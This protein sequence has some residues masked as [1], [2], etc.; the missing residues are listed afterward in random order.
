MNA[1]VAAPRP[2]QLRRGEAGYARVVLAA[3]LGGYCNFTLTYS[4]QPILPRLAQAFDLTPAVA[5][6]AVSVTTMMMA[7]TLIVAGS[8]APLI[9]RK[10]LMTA[11]I[12]ASGA[13]TLLT[14][15]ATDWATLLGLR[16]LAGQ[17]AVAMGYLADE[18]KR[19]RWVS[20]WDSTSPAVR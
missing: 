10:R 4:L 15:V 20:R 1:P 11:S 3:F 12:M 13:A 6:L 17:P 19:R 5:S 2:T 9:G 14:T 16:A 18:I 8:L 7:P